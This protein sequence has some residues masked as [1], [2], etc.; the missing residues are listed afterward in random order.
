MDVDLWVLVF[1][2]VY[3][4][5]EE[6]YV[7]DGEKIVNVI[8]LGKDFF[9]VYVSIVDMWRWVVED[10]GYNEIDE[11]LEIVEKFNVLL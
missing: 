11:G 10:D 8:N 5:Y 7:F 9:V 4:Y 3:F 6:K 1:I 2:L